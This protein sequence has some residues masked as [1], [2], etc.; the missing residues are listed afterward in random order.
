[1]TSLNPVFTIG[2]QIGE[3]IELHQ[4]LNPRQAEEKAV[5]MLDLVGIPTPD[6]G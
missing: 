6:G 3:A 4:G 5:E 1:M 2:N